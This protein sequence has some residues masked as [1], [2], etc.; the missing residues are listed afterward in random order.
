MPAK[1]NIATGGLEAKDELKAVLLADSFAQ[2]RVKPLFGY[3]RGLYHRIRP[4]S[5]IVSFHRALGQSQL[6]CQRC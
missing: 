3:S 2:V 4:P 6:S 1:R 5:S